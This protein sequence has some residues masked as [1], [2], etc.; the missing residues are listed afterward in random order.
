MLYQRGDAFRIADRERE[1]LGEEQNYK[2]QTEYTLAYAEALKRMR[3]VSKNIRRNN[4]TYLFRL[5]AGSLVNSGKQI[6]D[7]VDSL[8]GKIIS[9]DENWW[10]DRKKIEKLLNQLLILRESIRNFEADLGDYLL[11]LS[12]ISIIALT[13]FGNPVSTMVSNLNSSFSR[14]FDLC[15]LKITSINSGRV[16]VTNVFISIVALIVAVASLLVSLRK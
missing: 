1:L 12:T 11:H 15:A 6:D 16:T 4:D 14:A 8:L 2:G 9:C 3:G 7:E 13:D 5:W 10:S